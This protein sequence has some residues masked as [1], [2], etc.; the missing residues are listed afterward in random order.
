MIA[1]IATIKIT[2]YFN[3][4]KYPSVDISLSKTTGV[5][6][7][8]AIQQPSSLATDINVHTISIKII[9]NT[10]YTPNPNRG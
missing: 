8:P 9:N 10:T 7:L 5:Y 4:S 3:Y 2:Y 1:Q 6:L